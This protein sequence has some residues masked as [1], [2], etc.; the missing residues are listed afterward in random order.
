[1]EPSDPIKWWHVAIASTAVAVVHLALAGRALHNVEAPLGIAWLA[2]TPPLDFPFCLYPLGVIPGLAYAVWRRSPMVVGACLALVVLVSHLH[3]LWVM[4]MPRGEKVDPRFLLTVL[5]THAT[6]WAAYL[7][8]V[9]SVL[10]GLIGRVR[11]GRDA[12]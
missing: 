11:S 3:I 2:V 5:I 6:V 8:L 4:G 12:G 9:A 10:V 1:V 7:C